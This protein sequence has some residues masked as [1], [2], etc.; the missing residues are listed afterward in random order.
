MCNHKTDKH[1]EWY[2]G[3]S[4]DDGGE[5]VECQREEDDGIG[6]LT[7]DSRCDGSEGEI[8][9]LVTLVAVGEL[10]TAHDPSIEERAY[11]ESDETGYGNLW[12]KHED[13]SESR[14]ASGF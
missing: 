10:H 1:V 8:I 13:L 4:L 9:V 6:S 14:I 5:D 2:L 12:R 11:N 3:L 7:H